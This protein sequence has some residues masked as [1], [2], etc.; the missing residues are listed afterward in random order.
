MAQGID[1]F[2]FDLDGVFYVADKLVP[3]AIGTLETLRL[4]DIPYRFITN[5]TTQ[6]AAALN[7]KLLALGIPVTEGQL[8]TAPLATCNYLLSQGLRRCHLAV[9]PAVRED[10]SGIE[11]TEHNP[12][13][14]VIG[15]IGDA[16][17]YRLLDSLFQHLL[18]GA[19]LV[20]MHRNKYWQTG[21][22]LHVDIGAFVAGL[23]YVA[24]TTAVITGKPSA[25]FFDAA[26]DSLG[27]DGA[28]VVVVG[29][30]VQTDVGG[31][32]RAGL[33]SA[34]VKTGKYRADL[35]ARS[36]VAPDWTLDSIADLED[37]LGVN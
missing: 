27:M 10:F 6:S 2:L 11:H 25:A 20:A 23:E 17:S 30:D 13:A 4:R 24:S 7:R 16:W 31:A 35:V 34:L 15:D 32:Q 29:D 28:R 26:L 21:Q 12:Q 19:R 1:G 5:T 14:V 33:R 3:G 36:G 22:G 8:V 18:N 37:I 9:A